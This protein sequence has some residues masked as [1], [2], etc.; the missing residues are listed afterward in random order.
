MNECFI[1]NAFEN[2]TEK[3]PG[4]AMCFYYASNLLKKKRTSICTRQIFIKIALV[5]FF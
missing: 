3:Y 5:L 4:R 1:G 2:A